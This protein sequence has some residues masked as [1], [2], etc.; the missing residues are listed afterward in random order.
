MTTK[1]PSNELPEIPSYC[2]LDLA[3]RLEA[4]QFDKDSRLAAEAIMV[5][6]LEG[7]AIPLT[8]LKPL[9]R[10]LSRYPDYQKTTLTNKKWNRLVHITRLT[11]AIEGI[12]LESAIECVALEY[13]INPSTLKRRLE[14]RPSSIDYNKH[15]KDT[16]ADF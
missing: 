12:T 11:S 8:L 5:Y 7:Q 4:N 16:P 9:H 15:F 1:K 6:A 2:L 10:L 14:E 13:G 3:D